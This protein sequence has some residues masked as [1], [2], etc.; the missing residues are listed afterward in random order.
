MIHDKLFFR[1][2]T[3]NKDSLIKNA[4][5]AL[6]RIYINTKGS[7][8]NKIV[9]VL[10]YDLVYVDG[11]SYKKNSKTIGRINSQD[12]FGLIT[13]NAVFL[14]K[15]PV[16]DLVDVYRISKNTSKNNLNKSQ[17]NFKVKSVLKGKKANTQTTDN[18][19]TLSDK[20][21]QDIFAIPRLM[22]FGG[23]YFI[24]SVIEKSATGRALKQLNLS[25]IRYEQLLTLLIYIIACGMDQIEAVEFYVRDHIVPYKKNMNKDV[26]YHL[27]KQ[28][29][30]PTQRKFFKLKQS[31]IHNDLYKS[32]KKDYPKYFALDGSNCDCYSKSIGKAAFGKSKSGTDI[33]IVSYLSMIDQQTGELISFYPYAGSTPDISTLE[34]AVK[35]SLKFG[36]ND[37]CLVADRG[38]FSA[39]NISLLYDKKINFLIHVKISSSYIKSIVKEN[40]DS[41]AYGNNCKIIRHENEVNHMLEIKK[42]W[43]YGNLKKGLNRNRAPIYLYLF[44]NRALYQD[45]YD[46]LLYSVEEVNIKYDEYKDK[47]SK[48]RAQHKAKPNMELNSSIERLIKDGIIELDNKTNRFIVNGLKAVTYCQESAVW[49]LASSSQLNDES[50]FY[51]YRERNNIEQMY[52]YLKDQVDAATMNVSSQTSFNG[53][54]F[55]SLLASEFLNMMNLKI[56]KYNAKANTTEMIKLK[57]NSLSMTIKDL[58]LIECTQYAD[59]IIPKTNISKNYERLFKLFCVDPIELR[60][61]AYKD[62]G[63]E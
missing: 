46:A 22:K 34:G 54:L 58:D 61:E 9:Y 44:Y 8:D 19:S 62:S 2:L 24:K 30:E 4:K 32:G 17:F 56:K 13:F 3:M 42:T 25:K 37:Y 47:L 20:E 16:F 28:L 6:P 35:H 51:A 21:A 12:G 43:S 1:G 41:L 57:S 29:D 18:V 14:R 36:Y 50:A 15:Y 63:F 53:K 52:R 11:K 60:T 10:S 5:D 33:P 45:A 59:E 39:Y 7:G 49:M 23:S 40:I 38:Y 48:A 26:L 55:V 31:I 27:W